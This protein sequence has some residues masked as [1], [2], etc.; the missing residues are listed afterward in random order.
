MGEPAGSG[1]EAQ[2]AQI[3]SARATSGPGLVVRYAVGNCERIAQA[4]AKED[5]RTVRVVLTLQRS[6]GPCGDIGVVMDVV[7]PLE[8]PLSGRQVLDATGTTVATG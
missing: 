7:I 1:G 2:P 8:Q 3:L 4:V 6:P 5:A